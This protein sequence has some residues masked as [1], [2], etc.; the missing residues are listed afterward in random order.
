MK[1]D[2]KI[3]VSKET[4]EEIR[5][6][7]VSG[8]TAPA[9]NVQ[10]FKRYCDANNITVDED[11]QEVVEDLN[12]AVVNYQ[13]ALGMVQKYKNET[14]GLRQKVAKQEKTIEWMRSTIKFYKRQQPDEGSL[15]RKISAYAAK[16]SLAYR[17]GSKARKALE[18]LRA[19][20]IYGDFE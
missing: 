10:A 14:Q 5:K 2:N 3:K 12:D 16:E 11:A 4:Y 15:A 20:I 1:L 17:G 6:A 9:N 7:F 13:A 18:K 19:K 8:Y